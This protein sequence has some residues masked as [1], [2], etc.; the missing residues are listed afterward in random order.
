MRDV[1]RYTFYVVRITLVVSFKWEGNVLFNFKPSTYLT[2]AISIAGPS[3][4]V[5]KDAMVFANTVVM[6]AAAASD[7]LMSMMG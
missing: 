5:S 1:K 3:G 2:A 6:I 4:T 7:R